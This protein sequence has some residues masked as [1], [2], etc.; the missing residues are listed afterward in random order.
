MRL[1]RTVTVQSPATA[2][3]TYD[4]E[5]ISSKVW[6]AVQTTE[7]ANRQVLDGELAFKDYGISAAG[8]S[9]IFFLKTSTSAIESGRIIDDKTYEIVRIEPYQNHIEAIVRPVVG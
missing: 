6:T 9:N 3:V 1:D 7:P 2:D 4:S 5:G 8:I